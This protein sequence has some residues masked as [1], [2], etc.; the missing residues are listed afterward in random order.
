MMSVL[1]TLQWKV[2]CYKICSACLVLKTVVNGTLLLK[3][4]TSQAFKAMEVVTA[5]KDVFFSF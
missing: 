2:C 1:I 3:L 5:E 4:S